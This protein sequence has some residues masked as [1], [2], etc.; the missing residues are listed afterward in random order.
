MTSIRSSY[1]RRNDVKL[2]FPGE[3][4]RNMYYYVGSDYEIYV[5]GENNEPKVNILGM[6]Y[7]TGGRTRSCS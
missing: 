5:W 1:I 2:N 7:A 6:L 3:L 4:E